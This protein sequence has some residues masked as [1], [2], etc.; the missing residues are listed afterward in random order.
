MSAYTERVQK[1][2]A[3]SGIFVYIYRRKERAAEDKIMNRWSEEEIAQAVFYVC[4]LAF[5]TLF[6]GV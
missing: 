5:L 1:S 2:V 4:F 6:A 3:L